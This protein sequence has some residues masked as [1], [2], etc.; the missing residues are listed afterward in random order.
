MGTAVASA[1]S[2]SRWFITDFF[3]L[4]TTC[5]SQGLQ[6]KRSVSFSLPFTS[7]MG[8]ALIVPL[9]PITPLA[10]LGHRLMDQRTQCL[11][12]IRLTSPSSSWLS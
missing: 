10:C 8:S 1:M 12:I 9:T 2:R 3:I 7:C 11:V 5:I 4:P 6:S